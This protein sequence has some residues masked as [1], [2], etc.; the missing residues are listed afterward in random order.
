MPPKKDKSKSI[1]QTEEA[2]PSVTARSDAQIDLP[3]DL[4][5]LSILVVAVAGNSVFDGVSFFVKPFCVLNIPC[6]DQRVSLRNQ[7]SLLSTTRANTAKFK[8]LS[9][10]I[11]KYAT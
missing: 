4:D 9:N 7:K 5:Q 11:W 8:L 10:L 2:R 1:A 3:P 6:I